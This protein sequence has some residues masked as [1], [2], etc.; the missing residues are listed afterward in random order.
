MAFS[1]A[2]E[3]KLMLEFYIKRATKEDVFPWIVIA[4]GGEFE[5]IM[6]ELATYSA[7][8]K[9]YDSLMDTY[10]YDREGFE[11]DLLRD[12]LDSPEYYK[13]GEIWQDLFE[14]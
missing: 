7:A 11:S 3:D 4:K 8:K 12:M 5:Y 1:W 10:F 2:I 6:G 13:N 9:F 14:G